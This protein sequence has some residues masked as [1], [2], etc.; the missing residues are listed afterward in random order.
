MSTTTCKKCEHEYKIDFNSLNYVN[1]EPQEDDL[2]N[3][4]LSY[5]VCPKCEHEQDHCEGHICVATVYDGGRSW[6]GFCDAD[7][8]PSSYYI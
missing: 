5:C 8:T 7:L 1:T 3:Y 4:S 2:F 6:C